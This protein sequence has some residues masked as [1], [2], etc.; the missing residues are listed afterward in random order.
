MLRLQRSGRTGRLP[1]V[2]PDERIYAV[3]DIH[4][5]FDLLIALLRRIAADAA[6]HGD[7]RRPRLVFLGDYIDRGEQSRQVLEALASLAATGSPDLVFLRGNHEA[8]LL[9]FLRDPER[10]PGWLR[11]GG[12]E[13]LASFGILPPRG[14]TGAAGRAR[15]R[16]AL[17]AALAPLRPFLE[18]LLPSHRAG[19]VLF[20]HAAVD[21]G[22]PLER[23]PEDA[24]LWGHRDFLTED[25]VPGVRIVHGH[26]DAAGPVSLPGR[27]CV[28]TG[29]YYSGRLTAV[30][31]DTGEAF[32]TS[33]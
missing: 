23:Q 29:A 27:I 4:G 15:L 33:G 14:A 21:P 25:P 24:L 32:L 8:A 3:G 20:V 16:D 11:F 2:A 26:Y 18:G 7:G 1:A 6:T 28:D 13:T 31:L 22:R 5:R 9:D 30:R 10:H 19:D 17:A 12:L